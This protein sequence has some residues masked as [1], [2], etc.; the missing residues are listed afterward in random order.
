MRTLGRGL[1][2]AFPLSLPLALFFLGGMLQAAQSYG[3]SHLVRTA[4]QVLQRK[5]TPV[6][7]DIQRN[8]DTTVSL[9]GL[10]CACLYIT[11]QGKRVCEPI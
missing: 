8:D 2:P 10:Q 5:R 4:G 6:R 7:C 9:A 3:H 11:S 1:G